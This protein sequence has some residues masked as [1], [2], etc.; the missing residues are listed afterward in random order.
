MD[1]RRS[2]LTAALAAA[3]CLALP[4]AAQAGWFPADT[5][6]GPSAD[7]VGF[8]GI[9]VAPEGGGAVVYLKRDGGVAH[10]FVSRMTDGAFGPPERVDGGI[11]EPADQAVVAM[12]PQ[13]QMVVAW[14][15]LGRVFA[16][17]AGAG[18][19]FSPAALIS[20]GAR[21]PHVDFGSNGTAYLVYAADGGGGSDVRAARLQSSGWA[22]IPTVDIAPERAAGVGAGR[23]RVAVSAEGFGVVVWGEEHPDGRPRVYARRLTALS[24]SQHPQEVSLPDFNGSPGGAADSPDID[25]EDDG[26]FAW[27][28]FRQDIGGVSRTF[29]RR[30]VGSTFDGPTVL[31]NGSS[32]APRV[33]INGRGV[34]MAASAGGGGAAFGSLLTLDVFGPIERLDSLGGATAANPVVSA[35]DNRDA[36]V[37]WLRGGGEVPVEVRGRRHLKDTKTYEPETLISRPEWGPA[38]PD[39]RLEMG[40]SRI[41]DNAVGFLQGGAADRRVVVATYDRVP[42][43]PFGLTTSRARNIRRPDFVWRPGMEFWGPQ[44]FGLFIDGVQVISSTSE[45]RVKPPAP[46]THG[47]HTWYATSTDRRGQV[48][49]MD[50]KTVTVDLRKPRLRVRISGR[51]ARGSMLSIRVR[52]SDRDSGIRRTSIDYGDGI[53]GDRRR[54]LRRAY[55][56]AGRFTMTVRALDNAGNVAKRTIRLRIAG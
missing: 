52:A 37:A 21:D 38:A 12:G 47:K 36:A 28:V 30:L 50:Q 45:V 56:R 42:G 29:A 9:D 13:G 27:V 31:D 16:S 43:A 49:Q 23:P 10:V 55:L 25:I 33:A 8:G 3:F 14:V 20:A 7:I 51:R 44:T 53:R 48:A 39:G 54:T 32:T 46:L 6:D 17:T 18:Q 26:S 22:A 35:S 40:H 2:R 4:A 11:A 24:L 41:G 34:G 15:S 19:P 1:P 5:V